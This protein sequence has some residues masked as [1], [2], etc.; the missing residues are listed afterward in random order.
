MSICIHHV[1]ESH[2]SWPDKGKIVYLPPK[3][4]AKI[5]KLIEAKV[6]KDGHVDT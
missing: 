2:C 5:D 3:M 6:E 1:L 4:V